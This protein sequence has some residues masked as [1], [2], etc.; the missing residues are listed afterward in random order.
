MI[1]GQDRVLTR[2]KVTNVKESRSINL[3]E[4]RQRGTKI[5]HGKSQEMNTAVKHSIVGKMTVKEAGII[6]RV[7]T[8][9]HQVRNKEGVQ[10]MTDPIS[11]DL[12]AQEN[13]DSEIKKC[14]ILK[15]GTKIVLTKR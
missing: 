11:L 1:G 8:D 7:Q 14:H 4:V 3:V 12:K 13:L 15:F 10:K 2:I 6:V 5:A 9:A